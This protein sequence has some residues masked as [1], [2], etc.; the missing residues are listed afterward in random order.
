MSDVVQKM[1]DVLNEALKTD[2]VAVRQ[3][4][5]FRASCNAALA[6]HPHVVVAE[7]VVVPGYNVGALGLLNGALD[8]A[9]LP[10]IAAQY[11]EGD[12]PLPRRIVGFQIYAKK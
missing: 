7:N 3:V 1:V 10:K 8:A 4:M 5:E 12:V 9:G 11:E 6:D 2:P